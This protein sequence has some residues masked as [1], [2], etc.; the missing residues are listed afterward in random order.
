MK[1]KFFSAVLVSAMLFSLSSCGGLTTGATSQDQSTANVAGGANS[2]AG[3]LGQLS[4]VLSSQLIPTETQ[5]CGTWVYQSPAVVFTSQNMLTSLGGSVASSGIES[6]LQQ[7]LSKYGFTSGNTSITF[8]TDKTFVANIRGKAISGKYSVNG[9]SVQLTFDGMQQPSRMTPQL[10]NGTLVIAGDASK[11]MTFL[12]G[13]GAN[14]TNAQI[15]AIT[16]LMKQFDGMQV[17]IRL[18]KK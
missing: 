3:L 9:Q 15:G 18:Q 8:N 7:Y 14:S 16:G 2:L 12:Q 6:K 1:I 5:I 4:G 10:N 13:L 17:G 11:L